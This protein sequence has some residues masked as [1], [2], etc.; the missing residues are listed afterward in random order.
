MRRL[1]SPLPFMLPV[2][3][4]LWPLLELASSIG[5]IGIKVERLLERRKGIG[6]HSNYN[7]E[8][9]RKIATTI[10]SSNLHVSGSKVKESRSSEKSSE[11]ERIGT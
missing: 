5:R 8:A 6:T 4:V 2:R 11:I 3:S 1:G 10:R 9:I 7:N